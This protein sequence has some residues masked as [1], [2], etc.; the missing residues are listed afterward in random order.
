[1]SH[2]LRGNTSLKRLTL[3]IPLDEDEVH[4][5]IDSLKDNNSLER[6]ELSEEYH[7]QYFSE[8]EKHALDTRISLAN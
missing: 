1:M 7:S 4:D 8:S 3:R 2:I 5:I 6:L